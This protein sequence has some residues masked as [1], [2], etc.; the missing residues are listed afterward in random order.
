V[1]YLVEYQN[2]RRVV[3]KEVGKAVPAVTDMKMVAA[4]TNL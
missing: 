2:Y 1:T 4:V 3:P